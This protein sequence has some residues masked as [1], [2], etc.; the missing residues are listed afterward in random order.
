MP[1]VTP[2]PAPPAF[3]PPDAAVAAAG[4]TATAR[5]PGDVRPR[6]G[7]RYITLLVLA[8]FGLFMAIVA[9]MGYSLS[10]RVAQ[11]APGNQGVLGFVVGAGSLILVFTGPILGV[12][13]DRT[14]SRL[15]RR[16]P[17]L[18]GLIAVGLA[19]SV[20]VALAPGVPLLVLGWVIVEIGFGSAMAVL[21]NSMAD[22]LPA[23]Q[24]GRVAG[25]VGV[26]QMGAS[27]LGVA[28]A[29]VFAS[30][31]LLLFLVPAG[32][33]ALLALLFFALVDERDSRDLP[34]DDRVTARLILSKYVFP[35]RRYP[36]FSWN[37]LGRFLFNF[38][39]TLATTFTTFFLASKLGVPVTEIGGLVATVGAISIVATMGGA[40]ISGYL[41]D[42]LRRR[43]AFVFCAGVLFVLGSVTMALAPDLI[44]LMA[45]SFLANLGLG[46]FSAVDQA[47]VLDVLPERD[48]EAGR[49]NAIN[50]FSTTLPQAL[51]PFAAPLV[52]AVAGGGNYP[53]LYVVSGV[54]AL[55][56]GVVILL[57]VKSVR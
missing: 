33:G 55:A 20:I 50:Q 31:N 13:S 8:Q 21:T 12:L 29:S 25:L 43:R 48:T 2:D 37:W 53:L 38:G 30:S 19:G 17:W 49:F 51:A 11:L 44:V 1:D 46:V 54:F 7:A 16:R 6:V 40:G 56:G 3:A 10:V 22:R 28:V 32:V 5:S 18:P 4:S 35:V 34:F 36:D 9:S 57:R 39:L 24:R 52:L 15:G 27:I 45:G 23:S 14:R 26:A 47:L 42:K 41:S